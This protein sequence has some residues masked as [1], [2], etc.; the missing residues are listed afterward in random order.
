M[1]GSLNTSNFTKVFEDNFAND[2][3]LNTNLWP[4]HWGNADDFQ[5]GNGALTLTSYKSENWTNVGFQQADNGATAAQ[6]YG[7]Y[8]ATASANAGEGI[9][10]AIVMWPS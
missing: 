6:G 5:F 3:S 8:S 2:S 9:G 7:L 10:I 1:S 4:V